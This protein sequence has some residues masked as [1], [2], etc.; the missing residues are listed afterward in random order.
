MYFLD[1]SNRPK[2]DSVLIGDKLV[3]GQNLTLMCSAEGGNPP[4]Q[5]LWS[6]QAGL[7]N[8]TYYYD[9]TNKITR[10][11]YSFIVNASDNGE[12]Y[13]CSSSNRQNAVPLKKAL[14]LEVDCEFV[15]MFQV[16]HVFQFRS[17]IER[18]HLWQHNRPKRRKYCCFM[19]VRVIC[20][21]F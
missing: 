1:S 13:E 6:N 18:L 16:S 19:R 2:I 3:A 7:I 12:I 14:T 15:K 10:N 5:L 17:S 11:A 9:F 21:P 8:S 20:F 4:P